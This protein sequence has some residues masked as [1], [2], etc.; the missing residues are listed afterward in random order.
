MIVASYESVPKIAPI[1]LDEKNPIK[2]GIL[3]SLSGTMAISEKP[4]VDAELLAID[5][6]N[7]KGGVLGRKIQP[8]VIDG[9]S[10]WNTFAREAKYLIT[11]EHVNVVFGGWTSAS[12]KTMEPVFE[13]YDNLLF[14]PVQYEG[15][16][17]SPNIIYTGAAP[18]Q[19]V[20]PAV[21]WAY[22][23]LGK[24]F[25]LVGSDYVFPRSA[26]AIMTERIKELGG[27]IVGEE[28]KVL[29]SR[30]FN[31]IVE[32]I[33][34][35]HPDVILN[36]ING[37]SN[38]YFFDELRKSSITPKDIPTISF[39]IAENEITYLNATNIKGDYA[40]WNYFQSVDTPENKAF[41]ENFK[42]KYGKDRVVSDPMESAY[43]GVYLFAKAA[44]V[45]QSVDPDKI[46][47][48]IKGLTFEAPEGIVGID[49]ETQHLAKTVRIGKILDNGQFEIVSSSENPII[50]IPYP[51]YKTKEEWNAFLV[52]LYHGWGNSW[53]RQ[54]NNLIV[55]EK[56]N[57]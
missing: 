54:S 33:K 56:K 34:K 32:K 26:N 25:F 24:K 57:G 17:Q 42:N 28:Y 29:G 6:I 30:D 27:E 52:N 55:M 7:K 39:S 46:R 47:E 10:N 3:H 40:S 23:N 53:A 31:D 4:V 9:E 12:R 37:D 1:Q 51:T 19:Q 38:L 8:I 20:I 50:P 48:A 22:K 49:P 16:E 36:T 13:K 18:N 44:A 5:E 14:Y 21:E 35:A 43:V 45:A 11:Q 41:V 15:L 2:V